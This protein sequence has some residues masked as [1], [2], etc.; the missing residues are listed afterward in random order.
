MHSSAA[1]R[2]PSTLLCA[3]TASEIVD[4]DDDDMGQL[5]VLFVHTIA[6]G[7][8][9]FAASEAINSHALKPSDVVAALA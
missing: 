2:R 3:W 1:R 8:E 6:L 5:C 9:K 7:A 4:D